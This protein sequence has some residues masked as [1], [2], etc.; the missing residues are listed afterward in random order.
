MDVLPPNVPGTYA[1]H[2]RLSHPI[3]RDVGRL[4]RFHFPEGE[5][6]YVGSAFGPGGLHARVGRHLYHRGKHHWHIDY[7][8]PSARLVGFWA[9]TLP[10]HLECRWVMA[11]ITLP[12][13]SIPARGLGASDCLRSCPAH[14]LAFSG[15]DQ[16]VIS[17]RLEQTMHAVANGEHLQE[18][19][20]IRAILPAQGASH[21][22]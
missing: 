9:S 10:A 19:Q 14:L 15:F 4:G 1:L 3:E 8:L 2:L 16:Q 12:G 22:R 5:Y 18:Y 13:A 7:L 11:L 17:E 6:I 20:M 21:M